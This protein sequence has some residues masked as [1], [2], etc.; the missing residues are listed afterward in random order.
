M[1]TLFSIYPNVQDLLATPPEDLA[2]VLLTLAKGM[3][4]NHNGMFQ[5]DAV[6]DIAI[7][8]PHALNGQ[9]GYS[10]YN[11]HEIQPL[12]SRAWAWIER[13]DLITPA[14][15]MNGRNGWKMFTPKGDQISDAQDIQRLREAA[16]FPRWMIHPSIAEK[17][18]RALMRNDLDEAVFAAF[19]AV[20]EA[21]RA[22]GQYAPS[23]I[24]VPLM[25]KAF[26][27][28][29][30]PLTEPGHPE[31]EREALAHLFAGAIGSYKNPHSHRTVNLTDIREAQEQVVIA[32][33]LLRIVEA[34]RKP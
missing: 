4:Q 13:N 31:G 12:L 17:V 19:K 2:P 23:D 21:V 11:R 32:S 24:G 33:H 18:W 30:G 16:D 8:A 3:L 1:E 6:N 26:D 14:G 20:E 5:P 10:F 29:T 27:K 9:P 28:N 25:R 15:G 22:A 7:A 34:R